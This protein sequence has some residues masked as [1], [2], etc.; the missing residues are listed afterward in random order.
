MQGTYG[1]QMALLLLC[2]LIRSADRAYL[3]YGFRML[4]LSEQCEM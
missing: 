2:C 3:L 4:E 1:I